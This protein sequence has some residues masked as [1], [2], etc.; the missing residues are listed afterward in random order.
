MI[1]GAILAP[2]K[3][4]VTSLLRIM[5]LSAEKN[6]HKYHRVLSL[7][8]WS[9]LKAAKRLL[10]RLLVVFA[11]EG[12]LVFGI[13][14]TIERRR[15]KKIKAKG[16]YRDPVRSSKSHF[17]KTSGLRWLSAMLL[18]PISWAD[19]VWALPFLTALAPSERYNKEQGRRHKTL[20]DWS[21][22]M[23]LQVRRWLPH[24]VIVFVGDGSFSCI[25]FL[26]AVAQHV[27]FI[28][29]LRL[30]AALYEPIPERKPGQVGRR[31]KKGKRLPKLADLLEDRH[32]RWQGIRVSTWYG[33]QDKSLEIT[34]GT[35]LWYQARWYIGYG[36]PAVSLRWV[37]VRDP[38]GQL[39]PVALISTDLGLSPKQIIS[40]GHGATF[41]V[42]RWSVE[43]TFEE[44][45][46]HL[47]L[48]TQRQ[49]SD[50]AIARTTPILLGLFSVVTLLAQVLK[51]HS[52]VDQPYELYI[53]EAA[54]YAKPWPT[55]SDAIASV[56]SKIL[57]PRYFSMSGFE[58]DVEKIPRPLWLSLVQTL[59]YAA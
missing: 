28:T 22:Q 15:G 16:I 44:A 30:D 51:E 10:L 56:R 54:W 42:R 6:Y 13:D 37:L 11:P 18:S 49:W 34:T 46:A 36:K 31:R 7:S 12:P 40:A 29:R 32:T 52:A 39:D 9:P 33:H 58:A 53:R 41:F 24:Q 5:G 8:K 14:D 55:F 43:V 3:R 2:G 4:T 21:R 48:E 38:Q 27:T 50:L 59:A 45:R 47:G 26:N 17:V 57:H 35:G 1:L 19:R 20:L 23:I 25:D